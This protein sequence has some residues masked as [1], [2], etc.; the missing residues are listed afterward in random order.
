MKSKGGFSERE[1]ITR[2]ETEGS[3]KEEWKLKVT[4]MDL[5]GSQGL[6]LIRRTILLI[7]LL[8]INY[9][10]IYFLLIY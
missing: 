1:G 10:F 2:M 3:D 6:I 5:L 8:F 7:L 9:L 4:R